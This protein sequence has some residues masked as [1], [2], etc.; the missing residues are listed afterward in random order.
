MRS[1]FALVITAAAATVVIVGTWL[2]RT[3]LFVLLVAN[4]SRWSRSSSG[5]LQ[6]PQRLPPV[7]G[8]IIK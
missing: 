8:I 7:F 2:V 5:A 4:V 3:A 6:L 1:V